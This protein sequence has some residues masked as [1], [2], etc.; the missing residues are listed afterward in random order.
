MKLLSLRV[1]LT[2]PACAA[3]AACNLGVLAQSVVP[4]SVIAAARQAFNP[5]PD[6]HSVH[7]VGTATFVRGST[8][9]S[10]AF[11][12]TLSSTGEGQLKISL[13][14]GDWIE[15]WD[16]MG[17][18]RSC[19]RTDSTGTQAMSA[20]ECSEAVNWIFPQIS[21]QS[22]TRPQQVSLTEDSSSASTGTAGPQLVASVSTSGTNQRSQAFMEQWSKT[23]LILD[24]QSAC[25]SQIS[26]RVTP[27]NGIPIPITILVLYSDYQTVGGV[28]VP[29]KI[30]R[31]MN[32]NTYLSLSISSVQVS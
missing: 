19:D 4:S 5:G 12:F 16:A 30:E 21:L 28:T 2:L 24:P 15:R 31:R 10:G 6:I 1:C 7:L 23:I 17:R 29:H 3:F 22:A 8:M 13:D 25:V 27:D 26:F 32:G 9:D 20:A 14:S 11:D 18:G